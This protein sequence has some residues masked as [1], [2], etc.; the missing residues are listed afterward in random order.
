[1]L[2]SKQHTLLRS[3]APVLYCRT[4]TALRHRGLESRAQ[5]QLHKLDWPPLRFG[6]ST[7]TVRPL[8]TLSSYVTPL[9]CYNDLASHCPSTQSAPIRQATDFDPWCYDPAGHSPSIQTTTMRPATVLR[10]LSGYPWNGKSSSNQFG[11]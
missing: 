11:C 10:P 9:R 4:L 5:N 8:P 2:C 6:I 1:M 7:R 3:K